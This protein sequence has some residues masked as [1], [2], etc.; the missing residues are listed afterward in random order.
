MN[1]RF[2]FPASSRNSEVRIIVPSSLIISQHSPHCFN[3]ASLHRSTVASVCPFLSRTPFFFARSGN[4]CPGRLKSSGFAFSSTHFMA[5]T[6]R[7][8]AEIPVVVLI[9]STET[10]KAVSWLSEFSATI[11]GNCSFLT[12]S[13]DIGIQISPFPWVAI[14]LIFS[15]VANSAAQIKSPSF[16]LSGSSVTRIIFPFRSSSR[17]SSTESNPFIFSLLM[18]CI[19]WYNIFFCC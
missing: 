4:I 11:C 18:Q 14:K 3:P 7:S 9:W 5:V 8:A 10:V 6:E 16:S 17:A 15:V 12:Y 2:H 19:F 1:L 13:S